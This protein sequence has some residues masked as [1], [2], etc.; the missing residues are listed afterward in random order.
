MSGSSV[1]VDDILLIG[2][3]VQMLNSVNK[4]LNN[5]FSMKDMGEVAYILG[6][7]IYRDRSRHPLALSQSTYIDKVLKRSKMENSKKG[8]LPVIK[9]ISLSDSMSSNRKG[10]ECDVKHPLCL[11][12]RLHHV[13]YA[14]Y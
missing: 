7:M 10:E 2:N 14:K 11:C 6:I 9:G 1:Y 3:D 8:N 12:H 13:C 5:N 4:Y